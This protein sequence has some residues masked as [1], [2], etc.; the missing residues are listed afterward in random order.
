MELPDEDHEDQVTTV[1]CFGARLAAASSKFSL[2]EC[3]QSA[4]R[5]LEDLVGTYHD[6]CLATIATSEDPQQRLE[7][8]EDYSP[9]KVWD[10]M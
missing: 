8:F 9:W 7:D 1:A 4:M 3:R 6:D 2:W 5:R 10:P